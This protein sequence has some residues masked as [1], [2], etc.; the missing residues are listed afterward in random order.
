[1]MKIEDIERR[2]AVLR[3]QRSRIDYAIEFFET[4]LLTE[5]NARE[6]SSKE[7]TALITKNEGSYV[8]QKV[9]CG[10]PTCH[11]SKPGGE[12]HGPYWHLYTKKDGK[13]KCKYLG[14]TKPIGNL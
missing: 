14:K 10:K 8:L 6:K 5:K 9:K 4:Q 7:A 2:L 1:M 12:L 13:T 11:C 3:E